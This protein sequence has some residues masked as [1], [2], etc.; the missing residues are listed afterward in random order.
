MADTAGLLTASGNP[1]GI[2]SR[3]VRIDAQPGLGAVTTKASR[4]VVAGGAR[5]ELLACGLAMSQEPV[6]N[7]VVECA[8]RPATGRESRG[9]VTVPAERF[10]RVTAR[11]LGFASEGVCTMSE[12]K[13]DGMEAR[14]GGS[15]VAGRTL[16]FG[17]T[18]RAVRPSDRS[19][20]SVLR[21]EVER[22]N[23]L[24]VRE[25]HATT[26]LGTRLGEIR[27]KR[28]TRPMTGL[29]ATLRMARGTFP[30]LPLRDVPMRPHPIRSV[31]ARGLRP[32]ARPIRHQHGHARIRRK[33][34]D[35]RQLARVQ[36][37]SLAA[38][39]RMTHLAG[40]CSFLGRPLPMRE[41][42]TG[43]LMVRWS[44]KR[45]YVFDRELAR[46]CERE[47]AEGAVGR[48]GQVILHLGL[49]ASQAC[50]CR[51]E[52]HLHPLLRPRT[53]VAILAGQGRSAGLAHLSSV[54]DVREVEVGRLGFVH[55]P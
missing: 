2:E 43:R 35:R 7:G 40:C 53:P 9:H 8:A 50:L 47:V 5:L 45:R 6:G 18:G 29:A 34:H 48:P 17:M 28:E 38:L 12:H 46:P 23:G 16:L 39:P 26:P 15:V 52:D 27:Q 42:E 25:D 13:V 37:T 31:M 51:R 4:L 30:D 14:P 55:R 1:I 10:G 49:M 54:I 21:G 11:A 3:T 33:S 20:R 22:M 32:L 19:R 41:E 36:V 24:D 44:G